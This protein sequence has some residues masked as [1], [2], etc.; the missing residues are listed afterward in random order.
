MPATS[1]ERTSPPRSRART[2]A[3]IVVLALTATISAA[4][5]SGTT[6]S[7]AGSTSTTAPAADALLTRLAQEGSDAV[8]EQRF[9][10][11]LGTGGDEPLVFVGRAGDRAVA[12]V[13]DGTSGT[14]FTGPVDPTGAGTLR[15]A[16]GDAT[17]TTSATGGGLRVVVAGG[18]FDGRSTT[19]TTLA[20]GAG[21]LVRLQATPETGGIE[22]AVGGVIITPDAV[23]GTLQS[24][25]DGSSNTVLLGEA[26]RTTTAKAS[27]TTTA[28][29]LQ[30]LGPVDPSTTTTRPGG[31]TDGQ[32]NT[33]DL[34]E[35]TTTTKPTTTRPGGITDG[36][37]NTIDLGE[38]TA[39][40]GGP[41]AD[42]GTNGTTSG[43]R[44]PGATVIV[45][46]TPGGLLTVSLVTTTKTATSTTST[47]AP[48]SST[49]A[50]PVTTT[51]AATS[52]SSCAAQAK[53]LQELVRSLAAVQAQL[54]QK[55]RAVGGA[56]GAALTRQADQV[57]AQI[58]QLQ[59]QIPTCR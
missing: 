44:P 36:Q 2:C 12:Y 50:V 37:S 41:R 39:T 52:S 13:C 28:A 55:A 4:C 27:T 30:T 48:R 22:A 51:T 42:G 29:P 45:S 32:S 33:I 1:A 8:F 10:G 35:S 19:A 5:S 53:A 38:S 34:G 18:A 24:I 11:T 21:T 46:R 7:A 17:A 14:W 31:I 16:T 47:T 54:V 25:S 40:S 26:T 58:A 59:R 15:S 20:D 43:T 23:R 57:A 3:A 56:A 9:L 6:G 49:T